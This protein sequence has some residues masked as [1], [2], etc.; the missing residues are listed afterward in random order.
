MRTY[1]GRI[2][3]DH[4][5]AVGRGGK[6]AYCEFGTDCRASGCI[7]ATSSTGSTTTAPACTFANTDDDS[8]NETDNEEDEDGYSEFY[9]FVYR[10]FDSLRRLIET[11]RLRVIRVCS[12]IG[13]VGVML[14]VHSEKKNGL[15]IEVKD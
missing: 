14:S 12:T 15:I 5:F 13:R 4:V 9:P 10:F 7:S 11:R 3:R 8:N 1:G 6:S 2:E